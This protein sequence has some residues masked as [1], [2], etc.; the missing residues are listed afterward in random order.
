MPITGLEYHRVFGTDR[1]VV[2]AA[3]PSRLYYF[4]GKADTDEKPLLQQ[5]FNK[6]LN[7]AEPETYIE[8]LSNL[9]YSRLQFWSENLVTPNTFAWITES[10]IT[11]GEVY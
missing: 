1:Y 3:T 6:Y 7:I 5:V 8:H 9:R 10:G 4:V 11:Y 2:F